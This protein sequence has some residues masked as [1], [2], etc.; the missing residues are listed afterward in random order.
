MQYIARWEM[1]TDTELTKNLTP[2][3]EDNEIGP[4]R[5]AWVNGLYDDMKK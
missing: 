5:I 3:W 4:R 1:G 2:G